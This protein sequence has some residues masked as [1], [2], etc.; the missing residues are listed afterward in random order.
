MRFSGAGLELAVITIAFGAAGAF[1]DRRLN[2]QRPV[3][4]AFAGLIGFTLG[5]TR[6]IRL[7]L[8]ASE[9]DRMGRDDEGD[10]AESP[11]RR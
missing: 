2:F 9:S 5:M 6:F 3:L 1:A 4:S 11:G 7:A 10:R 8:A